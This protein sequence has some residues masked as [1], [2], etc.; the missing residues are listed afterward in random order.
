M[1]VGIDHWT[2]INSNLQ[3]GGVLMKKL[4]FSRRNLF[5]FLCILAGVL[6]FAAP[7]TSTAA[8]D[9]PKIK[10]M[11]R[12]LYLGAD[13]FRVVDAASNPATIPYVVGQVYNIMLETN[14]SARANAIADEIAAN[15]PQVIGL[16]EVEAFYKISPT[17]GN[18]TN[19]ID[20][21]TI[22][23][24]A[25]KA[26]KMDYQAFSVKNADITMPM[27]DSTGFS[28]VRMVDHDYILVRKGNAA[29][30]VFS[31]NYDYY[32]S[33]TI[34]GTPVEFKRGYIVVDVNVKGEDYRIACT[35]PEVRSA[36]GSVFR[37]Y[38]SA[39]MHE[40]LT[41]LNTLSTGDPKPVIMVG[42]FNSSPED[43]PGYYGPYPYVPPYMQAVAAGYL[44]TWLLQ[45]KHD[46]GYT[47]GFDE[48]VSDQNPTLLDT[49][50]DLVWLKTFD[51]L[52]LHK[53]SCDVVG[54]EITDM[55]LNTYPSPRTYAGPYLWPSDHAGVVS[56]IKFLP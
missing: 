50:I 45:R 32:L 23:N 5:K 35:H 14:F 49:R 20:F 15:K 26:R 46:E 29:E 34:G 52:L 44:D 27:V 17:T 51:L 56:D 24:A 18:V 12:N 37:F 4:V 9:G 22:L 11:T 48:F 2:S 16:N 13:I 28:Y 8:D 30:L 53:V 39:Q 43:V 36:T 1:M 41:T 31:K 38:Q 54:N 47:S 55:V 19:T 42:D 6:V 3:K 10:V 33:L 7:L 21:Y 40:L 25:L